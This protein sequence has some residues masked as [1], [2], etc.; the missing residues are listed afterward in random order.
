MAFDAAGHLWA[1]T[2]G[3]PLLELDAATG[4]IL[5]QHGDS[6]TQTLAIDPA[7]G[8]I[9]VSSGDGVEIFN[10]ATAKFTPLQRSARRQ[11]RIRTRRQPLG[12]ALAGRPGRRHPL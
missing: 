3:G 5:G 11:P 8:M 6:L 1:T 10:P 2:G 7:S 9:Y 4:A 12:N